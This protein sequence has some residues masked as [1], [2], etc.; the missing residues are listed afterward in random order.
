V[1]STALSATLD[2]E[3]LRALIGAYQRCVAAV[4]DR[5]GGF[6]AK[7]MGDGVLIYFGYP[8]AHEDDAERAVRAGLGMI[9]AIARLEVGSAHLQA[10]ARRCSCCQAGE[11][12]SLVGARRAAG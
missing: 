7:Y 2:P 4:I 8:R 9:D 1:G 5:A 12:R 11:A 10:R 3:D 6:V